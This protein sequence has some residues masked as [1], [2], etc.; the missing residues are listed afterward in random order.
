MAKDYNN[1]EQVPVNKIKIKIENLFKIFGPKAREFTEVVK[2][3]VDKDELLAKHNHVLG[4]DNINLDIHDQSIQVV[5]G[6]SGSGKSTLIRHV[7][8]LIDPTEG[9]VSVDDQDVTKLSKDELLEF[10]RTK[11]GMVFQRF[12]LFPHQNIIE[13]VKLGLSIKGIDKSEADETAKYLTESAVAK[14]SMKEYEKRSEDIMEAQRS[15]KF[16]YD[17]S[18]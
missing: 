6:L 13:N 16:I 9:V 2:Q 8:R 11:T 7:N 10:R 5:M 1:I 18:R 17:L 4:L 3:G 14:M 15:G 12:G